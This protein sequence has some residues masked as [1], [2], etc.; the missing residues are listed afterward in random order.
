[1]KYLGIDYGKKNVGIAVSDETGNMAFPHSVL[2]NDQNL[3]AK[4]EKICEQEGV[5]KIILGRSL[6]YKR[7]DNPIMDKIYEF[8]GHL[9]EA[10]TDIA[11]DFEDETLTSQEATR[12]IGDDAN[13]DARAASIILRN[14]LDRHKKGN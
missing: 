8:T 5:K 3:I 2:V 14:Y 4:I 1:M 7:Q 10:I 13:L 12:I 9:T 6:D 11:I